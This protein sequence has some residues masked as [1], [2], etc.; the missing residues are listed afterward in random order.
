MRLKL[1]LLG[2]VLSAAT[3]AYPQIAPSATQGGIPLSVG[4]GYSNFYTDWSAYESGDV[5]WLDWA[6]YRIPRRLEGLGVE[7]EARDLNFNRTGDNAKLRE[8]TA[9]G[10]PVY[11]W[12]HYRRFQPYG[13]FLIGLASIDFSNRPGDNYTHDTRTVMAP[14][15]GG[16]YRL[17]RNVWVRG[18]YEYQMWPDFIH[19]N[20]FN[21]KG[22]SVGASY[23]LGHMHSR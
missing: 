10:G 12:Q 15:G 16:E 5:L 8:D 7:A 19:H 2:L 22:F 6:L 9:A 17:W 1:A 4:V 11:Y 21:P 14:G 18:E 20:T 23:D 13:K 3:A